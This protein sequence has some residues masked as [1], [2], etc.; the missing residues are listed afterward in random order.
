MATHRWSLAR[1]ASPLVLL[2][3][4]AISLGTVMPDVAGATRASTASA[5]AWPTAARS[6]AGTVAQRWAANVPA[7]A[8]LGSEP[9]G[10]CR[11]V[12]GTHATCPIAIAIMARGAADRSPWRC[13]ATV[14]VWRAGD[15]LTGRR[16]GT[17]CTPFP[18]PA[19]VPDPRAAIGTAFALSAN[20][21]VACLP[22]RDRRVTCVMTYVAPPGRRCTAAASVPLGRIASSVA[23]GEPLCRARQV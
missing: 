4:G 8:R 5:D 20:G 22:A 2:A 21:D 10:R 11:R 13:S 19:A 16:S 12:D 7:T 14:M 1:A 17:H 9:P 23:L 6:M 18:R 3:V 15:E